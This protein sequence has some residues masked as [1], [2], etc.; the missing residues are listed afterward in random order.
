MKLLSLAGVTASLLSSAGLVNG[1]PRITVVHPKDF[2]ISTLGGNTFKI[3]QVHNEKFNPVGKGPRALAK[4]YQKYGLD[5][6]PEL[7]AILEEILIQLGLSLPKP[8]KGR[9]GNGTTYPN[10]TTSDQGEVAA[11]PQLFDVE[12]LAPV[13][14]GTP[15]Q[16]LNLNFDTGS[17]DLWVFSSETPATQQNGQAIYDIAKSTTAKVVENAVWSIRYGDGSGSSGNVYV[18]TVS[19]GGVEVQNQAVESAT[20]VSG[21]FTNDTASSGLVGLAFDSINQVVP[22]K[23]KTFFGNAMQSLAMPLFTANLKKAEAGNYNFGF[24]DPTEFTGPISFVDVNSTNGF[25]Q[26]EASGF[27][28]NNQT[29]ELAHQAIADT[30][31][32]LLMLPAAITEAYYKQIPSAQNNP[33]VGGFIFDCAETLPDLTLNIGAYKA[34]VQGE[35]IK[36]APADTDSFD[37]AKICFGGVQSGA[38]FPFAIYGDIFFKSQ[39]VVFHGGEVKLGFAPKPL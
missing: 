8:A 10:E 16:T 18:D 19:I 22:T 38:G 1:A 13:Q 2:T 30:G 4:V 25:W 11:M 20:K 17:S 7:L 28:I 26:F 15:P 3:A 12:Y 31:T 34:V 23:Q 36:F 27:T 35:L 9:V 14:I 24:I 6:P 21:S 5:F 39:F 29:V 32:T 37:T 33:T